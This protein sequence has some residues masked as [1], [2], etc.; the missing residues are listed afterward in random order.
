MGLGENYFLGSPWVR[1][2]YL[3]N[4]GK[5]IAYLCCHLSVA[6]DETNIDGV[7]GS[8]LK[9]EGAAQL[10]CPYR[11]QLDARPSGYAFLQEGMHHGVPVPHQ[12]TR[13]ARVRAPLFFLSESF[14][15]V[16]TLDDGLDFGLFE[17]TCARLCAHRPVSFTYITCIVHLVK[18]CQHEKRMTWLQVTHKKLASCWKLIAMRN[19]S[20]ADRLID[21][22][23]RQLQLRIVALL[24]SLD[25]AEL[26]WQRVTYSKVDTTSLKR[27][28]GVNQSIALLF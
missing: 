13:L 24:V 9:S 11:F 14:S 5:G 20:Q 12:N 16:N 22:F 26:N 17:R 10:S 21:R 2:V 19:M 27:E 15:F 8:V 28:I 18:T 4:S 23:N 6:F 1:K 7:K 25:T 3:L